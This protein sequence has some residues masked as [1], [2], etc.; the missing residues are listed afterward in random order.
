MAPQSSALLL[1]SS[2]DACITSLSERQLAA[3]SSPS[4]GPACKSTARSKDFFRIV[5]S[6]ALL[7]SSP[8]TQSSGWEYQEIASAV[9]SLTAL[10]AAKQ[11]SPENLKPKGY[12]LG[13]REVHR[14]TVSRDVGEPEWSCRFDSFH[15]SRFTKGANVSRS[16]L[17]GRDVAG[18]SSGRLAVV[19]STPTIEAKVATVLP[20][21][22]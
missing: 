15:L 12:S 5:T 18:V 21:Q 17:A 13:Q 10:E 20:S 4:T 3:A 16:L 22:D 8:S 6:E 14:A 9:V 19:I 2:L 11:I 7:A 1:E